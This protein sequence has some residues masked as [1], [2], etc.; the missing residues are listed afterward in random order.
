MKKLLSRGLPLFAVLLAGLV[1]DAGNA[2]GLELNPDEIRGDTD[3]NPV[4]VLQNRYFLKA[5]RPEIGVATGSFLNEAYTDTA[6]TGVRVSLFVNEWVGIEAQYFKSVVESSEDRLALNKIVAYNEDG[7]PM[8]VDPEVN[9]IHK[10]LDTNLT[11]APFYGKLNL[12]DSFII[13]SDLYFTGGLSKV[14]TDQGDLNAF[15]IGAGQRFYLFKAL[16]LR[17]DFRD[18][19]YTEKKAGK[20]NQRNAYS[21]DF[22][23]SYFFL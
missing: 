10:V 16:S 20:D 4:T 6:I 3:K 5:W 12:I 21:V 7:R 15:S 8:I 13:Y 17:I 14:T 22:G 23:V 11:Y 1:L 2:Y 18:R 19:I 9:A